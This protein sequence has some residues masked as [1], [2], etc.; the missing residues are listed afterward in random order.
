MQKKIIA[1]LTATTLVL[2]V[3]CAVQWKQL[4]ATQERARAVEEAARAESE[5][6]QAQSARVKELEQAK[7]HLDRQV[8]EFSDVTRTLRAK[9]AHQSSNLTAMAQF[10]G[11]PGQGQGGPARPAPPGEEKG[12]LFGKGMGEM[13]GKMMKDP[14]M[15][16]MMRGQQKATLNMMYGGLFKEMTLAPEEKEKLMGILTEAQMKNIE[17]AQGIF[18]GQ[19]EDTGV[20][21]QKRFEDTR[22]QTETEL[23]SLLGDERFAQYEDYQ[24]NIGERMQLDQLKTQLDSE[25]M[26]LQDQQLAQL[27][28]VMKEERA[29]VPPVI[30]NDAASF[31]KDFKALMTAENLEK[32]MQ[33][34]EDYDRRV[35]DRAGQFLTPDQMKQYRAF[36]QSQA[37]M[38]QFGL[39]MAGELFGTGKPAPAVE[40]VPGR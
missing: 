22:K 21:M 1:I 19:K 33:W 35:L 39:K 36:Q 37:A 31:P 5:T 40:A 11:V 9:E 14:A 38:Q 18:G 28:Q 25:K 3:V 6:Q 34:M 2:G 16:D 7:E 13:L 4:R 20:D 17:S 15:R 32:Q 26:P 23:K 10:L 12:G 27:L 29:A 8:Q 24:K 30:P